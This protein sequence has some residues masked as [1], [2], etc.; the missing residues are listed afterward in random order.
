MYEEKLKLYYKKNK[1]KALKVDEKIK[2]E[3]E[4]IMEGWIYVRKNSLY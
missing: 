3:I 1:L 2:K 4:N